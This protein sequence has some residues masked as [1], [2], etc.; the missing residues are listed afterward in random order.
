[1]CARMRA[2]MRARVCALACGYELFYRHFIHLFC[3]LVI[4]PGNAALRNGGFARV[5]VSGLGLGLEFRVETLPAYLKV[6]VEAY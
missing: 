2:F 5:R 4:Q 6:C 1:M 3:H